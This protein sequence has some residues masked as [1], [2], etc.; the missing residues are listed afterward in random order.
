[1]SMY[2]IRYSD[3]DVYKV[4]T[5]AEIK[6]KGGRTEAKWSHRWCSAEI[7]CRVNIGNEKENVA[8]Q[9]ICNHMNNGS[10]PHLK[11]SAEGKY[12]HVSIILKS[13]EITNN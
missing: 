1:M 13:L 3:N 11:L 7:I 2:L 8:L 5:E 9:D 10:G 4:C 6:S 12:F